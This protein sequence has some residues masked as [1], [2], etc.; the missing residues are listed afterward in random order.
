MGVV[1]LE[2]RDSLIEKIRATEKELVKHPVRTRQDIIT[3]MF[4]SK[5]HMIG[6]APS[7]DIGYISDP[8][9]TLVRLLRQIGVQEEI[10]DVI[11]VELE[12]EP[13][14]TKMEIILAAMDTPRDLQSW[15]FFL[16]MNRKYWIQWL[17][18]ML[19]RSKLSIESINSIIF[20]LELNLEPA[21]RTATRLLSRLGFPRVAIDWLITK[22]SPLD[23]E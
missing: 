23:D 13:E 10:I 17:A 19:E 5:M 22:I 18:R 16:E 20:G 6:L 8:D 11:I 15:P 21:K 2:D 12:N 14:E 9:T 7:K 4:E 1:S 3:E